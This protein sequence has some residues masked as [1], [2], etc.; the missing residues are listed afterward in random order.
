[1]G[2]DRGRAEAVRRRVLAV[3]FLAFWVV[4]ARAVLA[5]GPVFLPRETT[6]TAP[7]T[8]AEWRGWTEFVVRAQEDRAGDYELRER[9]IA[10]GIHWGTTGSIYHE[11]ALAFDLAAT[12]SCQRRRTWGDEDRSDGL[13]FDDYDASLRVL[14]DA[15]ANLTLFANRRNA[16]IDSPFRSSYRVRS[17]SFGTEMHLR[18]AVAPVS[19]SYAHLRDEEEF[20]SLP[21]VIERERVRGSVQHLTSLARSAL[22]L[23]YEDTHKTVPPQDYRTFSVEGHNTLDARGS[24]AARLRSRVRYFDRS[25]SIARRS[26]GFSGDG[27]VV[28][29]QHLTSF[30]RYRLHDQRFP[31]TAAA[32]GVREPGSRV[33]TGTVGLDHLLYG[34]LR[35]TLTGTL[36]REVSDHAT[37]D[38]G[39]AVGKRNRK[40]ID[41][42]L[43]YNRRTPAG[44]LALGVGYGVIREDLEAGTALRFVANEEHVLADGSEP[45]LENGD[46]D[47]VSIVVSAEDGFTLY[48]EGIDYTVVTLGRL[49]T[50]FRVPGGAIP[51][52]AMILVDYSYRTALDVEFDSKVFSWDARFD[53]HRL[54]SVYYRHRS[55]S[56]SHVSGSTEGLLDDERR[57]VM[58]AQLTAKGVSVRG[59][60]EKRELR[61][62]TYHSTR[63]S[64]GYSGPVARRAR[65]HLG[66]NRTRTRLADRGRS[67][68]STAVNARITTPIPPGIETEIEGWI[69]ID[70]QDDPATGR[71]KDL[72]GL[73]L[74]LTKKLRALAIRAG[75]FVRNADENGALRDRQRRFFLS[76]RREF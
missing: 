9:I 70:R 42:R 17:G 13:T 11:K 18:S 55:Q 15:A 72:A 40:G 34:S 53:A 20:A 24:S 57:D 43:A 10:Q 27:S 69:R 45:Q 76:L 12:L 66:A 25:G 32:T 31:G 33:H 62:E 39:I 30:A 7:L 56:E 4:C 54:A 51:D 60:H 8:I 38:G 1:M 74:R 65:F 73:R 41:G 16:W 14:R 59:E 52:G 22:S 2:N 61:S 6:D 67:W 28:L 75:V 63:V 5:S 37:G 64:L 46:V 58:G 26:F 3:S 49:T 29:S 21:R 47:E 23:R 71:D 48:E 19:L 50:L 68:R 36:S 35:S 44:R